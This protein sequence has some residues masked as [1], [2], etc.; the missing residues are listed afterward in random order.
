MKGL[1]EQDY[2]ILKNLLDHLDEKEI[3][4]LFFSINSINCHHLNFLI[5]KDGFKNYANILKKSLITTKYLKLPGMNCERRKMVA[6]K[7]KQNPPIGDCRTKY[8]IKI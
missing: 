4:K 5:S 8:L 1:E 3:P 6:N 7:M 2:L